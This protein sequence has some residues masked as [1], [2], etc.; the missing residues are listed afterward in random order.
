MEAAYSAE[1]LTYKYS[2]N[3]RNDP[4]IHKAVKS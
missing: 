2:N 3:R 4:N 1:V